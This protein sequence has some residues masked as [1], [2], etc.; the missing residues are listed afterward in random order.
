LSR[1]LLAWELGAHYGHLLQLA[2]VAKALRREGHD[3]LFAVRDLRGAAD[4]LAPRGFPFVQA[5]VFR[6]RQPAPAPPANHAEMLALEGFSDEATTHGIVGG[7]IALAEMFRADAMVA[8]YAPGALIA[9]RAL[10]LPQ[11]QIGTGFEMPPLCSPMPSIRPWQD[12]PEARLRGSEQQLLDRVNRVLRSLRSRELDALA[13]WFRSAGRI[14]T[15][16]PRDGPF[17]PAPGGTVRR[18]DLRV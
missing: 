5:P 18:T 8:D 11:V 4:V 17:R 12:I 16:F 13:E 6:R 9:G 1:I 10:G 7:W 14:Y 2:A 15:T 3:L